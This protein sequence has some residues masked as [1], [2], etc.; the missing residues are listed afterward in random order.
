MKTALGIYQHTAM[1]SQ[2]QGIIPP[3]PKTAKAKTTKPR[4]KPV[5]IGSTATLHCGNIKV[6]VV[7]K[8]Q[9]NQWVVEVIEGPHKGKTTAC[10]R[11][12]FT[13]D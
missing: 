12:N 9:H 5:K 8:D 10:S 2:Y 7:G 11:K 6:K 4:K 1:G 13:I 3:I